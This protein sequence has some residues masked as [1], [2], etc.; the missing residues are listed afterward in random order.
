PVLEVAAES[1]LKPP[2]AVD[3]LCE[4]FL[5]GDDP[6]FGF[7]A[8]LELPAFFDAERIAE[9]RRRVD[10]V[11]AGVVL[12]VGVGAASVHPGDVLV[13]ADL[14]RWEIQ[15]R[16]RRGDIGNLGV[17]NLGASAGAKYKRAFFVDWR[18]ADRW[19]QPLMGR[20]DF[21]LDTHL[22]EAPKLAS[23]RVVRDGLKA[24]AR[25]P[26]RTVPFFDP[27]IWG[28]QWMKRVCDLDPSAPNY[29]WC[30]DGVPEENSLVL[31]VNGHRFEV[32]A[33]DLVLRE[34]RAL[35]GDPVHARFGAEFPIR[36][37]LLDTMD[38]GNLS[39]Q[40]HPLTE[41]IQSKFGMHYT[42]DESYYLL[43]AGSDASV[44]LG[45][46]EGVDPER[47]LTEL[48]TAQAGGRP[49]TTD[50][51]VRRWPARRHDHF[52]IPAGTVHCSGRN[53]LVLEI[54][55]TPYI[56]T[57]KMWDW[58]RVDAT[59]KPRP[60]HLDHAAA[61]LQWDRTASWVGRHLINRV[62]PVAAGEGWREERTGLHEREFIETRR[63]W[64]RATAPFATGGVERG[65]V[66]VLNLVEGEA[67][68]VESP[69]GAFEPF[70]VHFAETFVV[71]AAVGRYTIRP[72]VG[73]GH[74]EMGV[75]RAYV[76]T[77][78][79]SSP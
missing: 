30:F 22:A 56:F 67:A 3:R 49:F 58:G 36:F 50:G 2:E 33:M 25:R 14:A 74:R 31:E 64:F 10:A 54:S 42:Q 45:W 72:A 13:L 17:P 32:P 47:V 29:A 71:P 65:S 79:E 53:S 48:R 19:K 69:D 34:P 77:G 28:G 55:A 37:D 73:D 5:G 78:I 1:A 62:E 24:V 35:L 40:V 9:L 12:V 39:L 46:E 75:M 23:G 66:A 4:P 43:D 61:N 76:R 41:Y 44:Y 60:I 59:G 11:R 18:V 20:A 26:F 15:R 57:F 6:V 7:L 51:H 27:G 21:F 38:G 63:H 8:P 70:E 16:Q 52:L 68:V